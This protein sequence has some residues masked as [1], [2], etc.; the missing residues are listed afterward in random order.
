VPELDAERAFVLRDT[1]AQGAAVGQLRGA[2]DEVVRVTA[3]RVALYV[4]DLD[5]AERISR[6]LLEPSRAPDFRA[7]G[8]LHLA[9]LAVAR[10]RW[11]EAL[12]HVDS[13]VPI[14]PVIALETRARILTLP[15]VP[16]PREVLEAARDTLERWN[17]AAPTTTF[18]IFAVFNGL[19]EHVRLY[20]LAL[21]RIRLGDFEGAERDARR[22]AT[23]RGAAGAAEWEAREL[24]RGLSES[25]RGHVLAARGEREAALERFE[26]GRLTV[27]EGLLDSPL[28]SQA[29][30]RYVRGELLRSLGRTAEAERWFGSLGQTAI[31][32]V[33]FAHVLP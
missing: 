8:H 4:R 24:A 22:L 31:D 33:D 28:G 13:V 9:D 12:S 11:R 23:L 18:P 15:F 14:A 21:L 29:L 7:I 6:L 16:A 1:V 5:G 2:K 30:E 3:M 17:G 19:H 26:R 10:G 27:S 20:Y 32:Q 25:V